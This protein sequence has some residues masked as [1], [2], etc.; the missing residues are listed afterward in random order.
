MTLR[1]S[2]KEVNSRS[3]NANLQW[4]VSVWNDGYIIHSSTYMRRFPDTKFVYSTGEL[5]QVWDLVYDKKEKK[6]KHVIKKIK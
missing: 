3:R 1:E 5:N 2:I 6:L 4:F